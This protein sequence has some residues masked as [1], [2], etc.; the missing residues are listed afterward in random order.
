MKSLHSA[1][2]ACALSLIALLGAARA[3]D[4]HFTYTYETAVL[5]PGAKEL[6]VSTTLRAGR[7][8]H[9]SRLDHRMEFEVGV[10]E[11]LM[12]AFYL[13]WNNIT[14]ADGPALKTTYSWEGVSS[15]WKWKLTDPVANA[16][17]SALYA[18]LSYGTEGFELEPKLLLDKKVGS[19]LLAANFVTEFEYGFGAEE[20]EL[21]EI[22]P[23]VDL[24]AT[25][26]VSKRFH[27]GLE[28]RSHSPFVLNASDGYD[29]EFS[30]LFI[31]P[32]VSY[33]ADTWWVSLTV[34]PQLP[35]LYKKDGGSILV[36]DD[37]EKINARLL[38]AYHL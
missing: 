5:P 26:E 18:E 34:L 29:Y 22:A 32:V 1:K 9:Y 33:A 14:E 23:E 16:L 17:G 3:N 27:A 36:L 37:H 6:E 2:L 13:N 19:W 15:E 8:E 30:S 12:S 35:A 38:F 25:Y 4:R 7:E 20:T 11:N 31:G 10:A 28:A 24:G 21:E